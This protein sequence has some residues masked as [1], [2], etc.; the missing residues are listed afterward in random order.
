MS[1]NDRLSSEIITGPINAIQMTDMTR[2]ILEGL[3]QSS[4]KK[5]SLRAESAEAEHFGYPRDNVAS[6]LVHLYYY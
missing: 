3:G 6:N 5:R 4:R 1:T 2:A